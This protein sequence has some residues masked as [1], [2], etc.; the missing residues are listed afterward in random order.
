MILH[1]KMSQKMKHADFSNIGI[2]KFLRYSLPQGNM[3]NIYKTQQ[4]NLYVTLISF[5]MSQ[6]SKILILKFQNL[7]CVEV[8]QSTNQQNRIRIISLVKLINRSRI[9]QL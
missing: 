2:R 9:M 7:K 4:K 3:K 1:L 6:G 5:K 8:M